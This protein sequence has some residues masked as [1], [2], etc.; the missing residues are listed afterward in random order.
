MATLGEGIASAVRRGFCQAL[1]GV[2]TGALLFTALSATT[3]VGAAAGLAT[4]AG[5][6]AIYGYGCN[7]PLPDDAFP[8]PPFTG[9]Q[10]AVNYTVSI[11]W[12]GTHPTSSTSGIGTAFSVRGPITGARSINVDGNL[13]N[14]VLASPNPPSNT[15]GIYSAGGVG[16][17]FDSGGSN[18]TARITNVVRNGGGPDNCGSL[19]PQPPG[20]ITAPDATV[21]ET[22]TYINNEGDTV[23]IPIVI[24]YGY[25]NVD[26]NGQL[27][28]PISANLDL[29]PVVNFNGNF[30]LQTGDVN[31]NLGDPANPSGS[32]GPCGNDPA[33][34]P[35][36]PDPTLP[37]PPSEPLPP[38]DDVR[39]ERRKIMRG[40]QVV[41]TAINGRTT[42]IDQGNN[43][44]IY[45]PA[46]G[47]VN[48]LI[49]VGGKTGWTSDIP[50]KNTNQ[51]IECPWVSGAIDV[52]GTPSYNNAFTV[53]PLYTQ[54]SFPPQYPPES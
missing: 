22:V 9:G 53:T 32:N 48:F 24:A 23:N 3:G 25:A 14:Q 37:L 51:I 33:P 28:I 36:I 16:N 49:Q 35:D 1:P 21:D 26:V 19:P 52:K 42:E 27:I 45:V 44:D 11:A 34:N 20:P 40:C 17:W 30:N 50:V 5:A 13:T 4:A 46:L 7:R 47:Y 2:V 8:A 12:T 54:Q 18:P 43:P 38:G 10:C 29:N 41:T 6:A 15:T 39:P 31:I